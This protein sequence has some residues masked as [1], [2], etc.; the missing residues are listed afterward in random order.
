M[1]ENVSVGG[2]SPESS[3]SAT[4]SSN[5]SPPAQGS[6]SP[7]SDGTLTPTGADGVSQS[8]PGASL[9]SPDTFAWDDWDGST[10]DSFP[11]EVRPWAEKFGGHYSPQIEKLQTQNKDWE[12][13]LGSLADDTSSPD[14]EKTAA[15]AKEI[16]ALK[17]AA[18][19]STGRYSTLE[20]E[21]AQ[22]KTDIEAEQAAFYRSQ[23]AEFIRQNEDVF[24]DVGKTAMVSLLDADE[25]YPMDA[26]VS[27]IRAG[28]ASGRLDEVVA[29]ASKLIQEKVPANRLMQLLNIE[30][31]LTPP[32][33][34]SETTPK[35][36][37]SSPTADLQGRGVS[38]P[39]RKPPERYTL[40]NLGSRL[41]ARVSRA[42]LAKNR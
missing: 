36:P 40:G 38:G 32:A 13:F 30:A 7:P 11:E 17:A 24:D 29:A 12:R 4:P 3:G 15:L 21:Y 27:A 22:Y 25:D 18:E 2:L 37:S 14:T 31:G 1:S 9:L 39:T 6:E 26:L 41:G 23:A 16:A 42:A 10:Y 35:V 19:E 34:K 20:S 33:P 8:T 5:P 28:K